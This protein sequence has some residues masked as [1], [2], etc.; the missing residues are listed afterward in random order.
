MESGSEGAKDWKRLSSTAPQGYFL[1]LAEGEQDQ[2]IRPIS[3][4]LRE[5]ARHW[6]T[7]LALTLVGGIAGAAISLAIP[8]TYRASTL[9]APVSPRSAEGVA[10]IA[11]QLG[12]LAA[13]AGLDI[14]PGG[15]S[16]KEALAILESDGFV[17]GFLES[18][19]LMPK[20]FPDRWDAAAGAWRTDKK[21]PTMEEGVR[22]FQSKV[23]AVVRDRRNGLISVSV[24]WRSRELAADWANLMV[25]RIN[26]TLRNEAI[27]SS[28]VRIRYLNDEFAKTEVMEMRRAISGLIQEQVSTAMLANVQKE[29]AFKVLDRAV[30]PDRKYRPR[31]ALI[32]VLSAFLGFSLALLLVLVRWGRGGRRALPADFGGGVN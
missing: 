4:F 30:S 14:E 28:A 27:S 32:A 5:S 20:L 22:L 3:G 6:K 10:G 12:G 16:K 26:S 19:G 8:P 23:R 17:R 15:D 2:G 21:P 31:R 29:Y 13:L 18:E 1:L 24:Q 9:V 11:G 7:I 25:E